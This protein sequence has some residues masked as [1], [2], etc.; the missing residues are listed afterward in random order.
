MPHIILEHNF[1]EESLIKET[2]QSLFNDL[3][4]HE[5]IKQPSV[6]VRSVLMN[7]V[8]LGSATLNNASNFAHVN[9]KLL[10]GR[11]DE[12]KNQISSSLL[13]VLVQKLKKGSFSVEVL[14]LM[15]YSKNS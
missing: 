2:C 5:T 12:L 11:S 10:T 3:I 8:F 9:L 1:K 14:E 7:N 15:N 6:K 13:E 4:R